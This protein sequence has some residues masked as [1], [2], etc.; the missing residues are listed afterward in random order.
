MKKILI[1][2]AL[3]CAVCSCAMEGTKA[4]YSYDGRKWH[5]LSVG[6][7]AVK[8]YSREDVF[9]GDTIKY[10]HLLFN[11]G[12]MAEVD[13]IKGCR[14]YAHQADLRIAV[15]TTAPVEFEYCGHTN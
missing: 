10:T 14:I 4:L 2:C 5:D 7:V 8:S 1:F 9:T 3:L 12:L 13:S 15:K 11:N 6:E